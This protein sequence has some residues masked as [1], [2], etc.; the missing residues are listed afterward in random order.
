[1]NNTSDLKKSLPEMEHEFSISNLE[2]SLTKNTYSGNFTCKITNIKTQAQIKKLKAKL[3]EGLTGLDFGVQKI[4]E[5]ISYLRYTIIDSP[6]WWK[7]SDYGY[8]LYDSN[9]VETLYNE[10]LKFEESWM[11][12]VW[13]KPAEEK[14][15]EQKA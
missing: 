6:K 11:E 5:M 7:D 12:E 15:I 10:V 4:H 9:I 3:D 14:P 1:M 2:G 13:G 8:E